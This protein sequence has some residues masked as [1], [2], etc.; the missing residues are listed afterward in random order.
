MRYLHDSWVA[1]SN[2]CISARAPSTRSARGPSPADLASR[3]R[4][5]LKAC[6]TTTICKARVASVHMATSRTWLL[7]KH[8]EPTARIGS[9]L[10]GRDT[11]RQAHPGPMETQPQVRPLAARHSRCRSPG[12]S[13]AVVKIRT[14]SKR[15]CRG[16]QG[17]LAF[18]ASSPSLSQA[19]SEGCRV[20]SVMGLKKATAS[21][22]AVHQ[23][24]KSTDM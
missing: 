6:L 9:H 22:N 21:K 17:F 19:S 10:C 3:G 11:Q 24:Q 23:H 7:A 5:A 1:S 13:I 15:G 8:T 14:R 2:L 18:V 12:F 20:R 16:V 4:E